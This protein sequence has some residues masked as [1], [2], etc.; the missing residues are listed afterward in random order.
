[1]AAGVGCRRL[2]GLRYSVAVPH[3]RSTR[4]SVSRVPCRSTTLSRRS[5]LTCGELAGTLVATLAERP[6]FCDLL[7]HVTLSLEREVTYE[8]VR[9]FKHAAGNAVAVL[10][11][12]IST[13]SALDRGQAQELVIAIIALTAPLW[14][15]GH[16]GESLARLYRE[17]PDVAHIGIDFEPTLTR[18]LAALCDGLAHNKSSMEAPG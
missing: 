13:A 15:A 9:T 7:T 1:M 14:Q 6:L 3:H 10:T 8:R 16:P 11:G 18:L 5:N 17:E 12:A 2:L 4:V